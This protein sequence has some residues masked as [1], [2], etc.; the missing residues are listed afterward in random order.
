MAGAAPLSKVI[1]TLALLFW[2]LQLA[3]QVY[4]NWRKQSTVGLS[5]GMIMAWSVG[6]L[7]TAV[8]SVGARFSALFLVQPNIF[9]LFSLCCWAQSFY[10]HTSKQCGLLLGVC[11]LMLFAAVEL[12][13]ALPLRSHLQHSHNNNNDNNDNN[14]DN[15]TAD[16][17]AW[18]LV[19]LNALSAFFFIAGFIPQYMTIWRAGYV[20]G[21]SRLFLAIDMTGAVFSV[22][23]LALQPPFTG[24]AAGSYIAVFVLDGGIMLLSFVCRA[25][26]S[27]SP[28]VV[29]QPCSESVTSSLAADLTVAQPTINMSS[30]GGGDDSGG[31]SRKSSNDSSS[32][33]SDSRSNR[34]VATRQQDFETMV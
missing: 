9:L 12:A 18:P 8:A 13:A 20:T 11:A 7:C 15:D 14:D 22:I 32:T 4:C 5:S 1:E 33:S 21:I 27:T 25:G 6:S 3:P 19:L 31:R 28:E 2:S 29:Y 16:S 34:N 17:N 30:S 23:A 24:L 10:Y 26:D